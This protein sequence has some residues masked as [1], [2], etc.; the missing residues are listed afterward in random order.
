[1]SS[2]ASINGANFSI[3]VRVGLIHFA[4]ASI[5]AMD[6]SVPARAI[7]LIVHCQVRLLFKCSLAHVIIGD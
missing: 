3:L 1:M 2:P 5:I 4:K 7:Y 6:V